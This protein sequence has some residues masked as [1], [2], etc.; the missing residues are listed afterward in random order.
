MTLLA[1]TIFAGTFAASAYAIIVTVASR[2]DRILS[3]LHGDHQ[4]LIMENAL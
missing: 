2:V 1:F 3:A 4:P